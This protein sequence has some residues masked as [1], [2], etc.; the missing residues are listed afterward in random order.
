M[1]DKDVLSQ[2]EIDALL[3]SVD[4]TIDDEEAQESAVEAATDKPSRKKAK[5][6]AQGESDSNLEGEFVADSEI[7]EDVEAV[8]TLNFTGQERIVKG[9]LPVL[10]KIYDRAVRLFAADIYHL[11]A[12]DFEITQDPLLIIKHKD[13]MKGLPNPSLMGIYKFKP[14]RGKGIILFDSTFVYEKMT[15]E[16]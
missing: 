7:P 3:D 10:D 12:H 5:K 2:E 4:D 16:S 6:S 13:F 11:T 15:N 8:K 1:P 9:Q 14:L